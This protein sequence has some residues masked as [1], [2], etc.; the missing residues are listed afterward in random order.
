MVF[1]KRN[2]QPSELESYIETYS[3]PKNHWAPGI[4]EEARDYVQFGKNYARTLLVVDYPNSVRGNW[5]TRLYR[6][7]GNMNVSTHLVPIS[8][9][10]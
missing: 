5:L 8:S 4:I 1:S 6:F 3:V 2:K 10:K 9:E 7:S